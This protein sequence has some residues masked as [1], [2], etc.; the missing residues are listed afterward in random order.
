MLNLSN[1]KPWKGHQVQKVSNR[2]AWEFC[3]GRAQNLKWGYL[4]RPR[5]VTWPNETLGKN[6][7]DVVKM[8]GW[9]V[10][11]PIAVLRSAVFRLSWKN[12]TGGHRYPHPSGV[13]VN[14]SCH[15]L[16]FLLS[17]TPTGLWCQFRLAG[18]RGAATRRGQEERFPSPPSTLLEGGGVS[19]SLDGIDMEYA[20]SRWKKTCFPCPT[21]C[22]GD[23]LEHMRWQTFALT[24]FWHTIIC[25]RTFVWRK[26]SL[27]PEGNGLKKLLFGIQN[28]RGDE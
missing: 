21:F 11:P 25:L 28:H 7:M 22:F 12:L 6:F 16:H 17:R 27:E 3:C 8:M 5:L 4:F 2:L 18:G 15:A 9:K 14:D 1:V 19:P 26:F 10:E 24:N 20:Y 23:V 13:R